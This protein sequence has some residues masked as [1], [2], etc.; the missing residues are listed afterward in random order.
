MDGPYNITPFGE[1]LILV[2]LALT[3]LLIA[4]W[5]FLPFAVFGIKERMD[6]QAALSR[7]ILA[8][9]KALRNDQKASLRQPDS[10]NSA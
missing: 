7:E 9:L 6:S 10:R 5:V 2:V 3:A 1:V 8:E 4:V